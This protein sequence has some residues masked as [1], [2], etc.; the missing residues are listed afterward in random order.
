MS[1]AAGDA[2]AVAVCSPDRPLALALADALTT[3]TGTL[4]ELASD[5][6]G[7]PDTLRRHMASIQSVDLTTQGLHAIA[8]VL[9]SELPARER[10]EGVTL[11]ALAAQLR[12]D[13]ESYLAATLDV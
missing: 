6:G 4:A 2:E 8:G 5:L 3:M 1:R 13:Y 11:E 10:L 9:R 7:S 12:L